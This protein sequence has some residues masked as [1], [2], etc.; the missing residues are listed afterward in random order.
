MIEIHELTKTYGRTSTAGQRA[1]DRVSFTCDPGTV[2]G[3]LGPNGAGKSTTL[4]IL[5]GLTQPDSGQARICGRHYQAIPNPARQVGVLL[6]ASAH[7]DG[8]SGLEAL[9]LGALTMGLPATRIGQVLD[10]VGLTAKEARRRVGNYSLGMRQRLGLAHALLG[11]PAVLILD[12]PANGLDPAGIHWMRQLLRG[13]AD[14][15][16]TVLLSSHLLRE[17]EVVADHIVMIGSGQILR[18]GATRELLTDSGTW[19]LPVPEHRD[20]FLAALGRAGITA[21][22]AAGGAVVITAEAATVGRLAAANQLAL[23]ELRPTHH[24]G[25]EELF[26]TLTADAQRDQ[27]QTGAAA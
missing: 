11:D 27:T 8:R 6:D 26:L 3:F 16:G 22:P 12:E 24:D 1:V 21:T 18:Q 17:V 4:R 2:T 15:G 25:I 7:H 14:R 19:A 10:L 13:H 23:S 5:A 9:R 20:E